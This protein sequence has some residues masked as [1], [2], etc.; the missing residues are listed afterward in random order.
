MLTLSS[1]SSLSSRSVS[2]AELKLRVFHQ[3]DD[4]LKNTFVYF[5]ILSFRKSPGGIVMGMGDQINCLNFTSFM[6]LCSII[7]RMVPVVKVDSTY[8]T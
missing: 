6:L 1:F 2:Q 3:L 8:P 7:T 5:Q 4:L